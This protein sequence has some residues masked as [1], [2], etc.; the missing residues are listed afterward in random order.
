MDSLEKIMQALAMG[1]FSAR[2]DPRVQGKL[3]ATVDHALQ[4]MDEVI[5]DITL[6]MKDV[7]NCSFNRRVSVSASGRFSELKHYINGALE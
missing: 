6:V 3:K 7:T 1:D 5:D 2:M 4:S